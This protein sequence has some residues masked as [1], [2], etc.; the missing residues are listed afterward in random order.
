MRVSLSS[1]VK[2]PSNRKRE[3][4]LFRPSVDGKE[5]LCIESGHKTL[6]VLSG[7]HHGSKG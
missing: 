7:M 3:K 2:A 4:S 5:K 1:G 6:E